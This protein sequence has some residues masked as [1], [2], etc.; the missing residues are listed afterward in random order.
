MAK[1]VVLGA[2]ESGIGAALLGKRRGC[3]VLV[4]DKGKIADA[5]QRELEAAGI[6][7]EQGGHSFDRILA[8]DFVVKSPGIP[9]H[10][11]VVQA[12]HDAE[13]PLISEIEWAYR[14]TK[15]PVIAITGSNG[16]TTT[17]ALI[18]HLLLSAGI[19]A[20]LCGNIGS[21]FARHT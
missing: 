4:S 3:E 13:I 19:K 9:N 11:A 17:T 2:A 5:Y 12:V 14:C 20:A 15:V 8:A 7:Y 6:E 10:A 16:K 1:L 21:S 18:H